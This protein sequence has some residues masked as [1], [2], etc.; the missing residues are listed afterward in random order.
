LRGV[1]AIAALTIVVLASFRTM[2]DESVQPETTSDGGIVYVIG[3]AAQA[4]A[5]QDAGGGSV[6]SDLRRFLADTTFTVGADPLGDDAGDESATGYRAYADI[7]VGGFRFGGSFTQSGDAEFGA[8]P[9]RSFGFGASYSLEA[10]T[11]GINWSRGDYD[12]VFLDVGGDD[13]DVIAFTSSYSLRPGVRVNGL[14]E[15]SEQQPA[16]DGADA[17]AFTVGIGTLISF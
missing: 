9:A 12:E 17:G 6:L 13:G 14:L 3:G 1:A 16:E 4:P 8:D 5:L 15:Y 7:G 10:L 2:A 11:V